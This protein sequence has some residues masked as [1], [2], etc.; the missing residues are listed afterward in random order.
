MRV[1]ESGLTPGLTWRQYVAA[2]ENTR[3]WSN[4]EE[5]HWMHHLT[6]A[7]PKPQAQ[8]PR[9][10]A[11]RWMEAAIPVPNKKAQ[12]LKEHRR[13]VA[14]ISG[15]DE[16]AKCK[17]RIMQRRRILEEAERRAREARWSRNRGQA[18]EAVPELP[19]ELWAKIFGQ[20]RREREQHTAWT[21]WANAR[22]MQLVVVWF[23]GK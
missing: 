9:S 20:G 15:E 8:T 2:I 12:R 1:V 18:A 21:A 23:R 7:P 11:P 3:R 10:Q 22:L 19:K 5:H 17:Q 14:L 16:E 13:R 4:H 6:R